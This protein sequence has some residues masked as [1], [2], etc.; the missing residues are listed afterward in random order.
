MSPRTEQSINDVQAVKLYVLESFMTGYHAIK[1]PSYLGSAVF[2][3]SILMKSCSNLSISF[4]LTGLN[5]IYLS[6][7]LLVEI[8]TL[9]II[10]I[11]A[12]LIL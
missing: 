7:V 3:S 1:I 2:L 9:T 6:C 11:I 10:I 8:I 4:F 5:K 12:A